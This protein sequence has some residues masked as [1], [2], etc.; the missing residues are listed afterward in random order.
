MKRFMLLILV[1]MTLL[2]AGC[3]SEVTVVIP[4][5]QAPEITAARFS[6]D[7]VNRFVDGS[8][9]FYAPDSD[10]DTIT[11]SVT[12]SRGFGVTRT[13]TDLAAFRGSVRGTIDFTIDYLTYLPDTYTISVHLTDL[14]G[15]ISN[16]VFFSF[17]VP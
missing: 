6:Q 15:L 2:T 17:R 4:L 10:L 11:I 8:V 13:V 5:V 16:P 7:V 9:D 12:D 3:G 14:N 1:A